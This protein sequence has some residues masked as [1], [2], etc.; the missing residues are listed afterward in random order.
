MRYDVSDIR[1]KNVSNSLGAV[2]SQT[3]SFKHKTQLHPRLG[4]I[5]SEVKLTWK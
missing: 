3:L 5:F 1:N 2:G 4:F